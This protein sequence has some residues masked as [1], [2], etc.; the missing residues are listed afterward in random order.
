MI[1]HRHQSLVAVLVAAFLLAVG[2]VAA[3]GG[4]DDS[5]KGKAAD[6]VVARVNGGDV[7][8]SAVEAVR[9]Q[10]RLENTAADWATGLTGAI[11]REL[12]RQEAERLGVSADRS[13]IDKRTAAV[14]KS[15]GGDAALAAALQAADATRDQLRAS[16]E[17]GVLRQAVQDERY[18][19]VA[20]TPA[21]ARAFYR[22]NLKNLFTV[23][24]ALHLGAVVVHSERIAENA[25]ERIQAGTPFDQVSRQFST[26]PELKASGGD[27]GWIQPS[28]I[29][30][31]LHQALGSLKPGRVSKP[32]QGPGG[33]YVLK[34]LGRR[35]AHVVPFAQVRKSL[36]DDLTARK[37]AAKLERWLDTARENATIEKL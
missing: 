22:S 8:R 5:P 35:A 27:M 20:A 33:W 37:R 10:A 21:A 16:V 7:H 4:S 3:C 12:L 17:A 31:P 30:A 32:V 18:A 6:D 14:S 15:L 29:P 13:E 24:E 26:D 25:R 28:S 2:L 9:A 19:D 23:P 36:L 34:V 11:D 1:Q